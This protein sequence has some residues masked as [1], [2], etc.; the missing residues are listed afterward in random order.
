MNFCEGQQACWIF[1]HSL[2]S[3]FNVGLYG[4]FLM[5]TSWRQGGWR[6]SRFYRLI[7][8]ISEVK[9]DVF[10]IIETQISNTILSP[11]DISN[12]K[13]YVLRFRY[14]FKFLLSSLCLVS[15]LVRSSSIRRPVRYHKPA[16]LHPRSRRT[17]FVSLCYFCLSELKKT[18]YLKLEFFSAF[19]RL[20]PPS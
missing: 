20:P 6:L 17:S 2:I 5:R 15:I 16:S 14:N 8:T 13:F 12:H 11:R 7:H 4:G 19:N 10:V 9:H 3:C 18:N 1:I